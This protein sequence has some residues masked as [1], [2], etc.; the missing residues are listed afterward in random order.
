MLTVITA[1]RWN[2]LPDVSSRPSFLEREIKNKNL[3]KLLPFLLLI[4]EVAR[5]CFGICYTLDTCCSAN[6]TAFHATIALAPIFCHLI[7]GGR[8]AVFILYPIGELTVNGVH[9]AMYTAYCSFVVGSYPSC[10]TL[11]HSASKIH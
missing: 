7:G 5:I 6:A 11:V 1:S 3:R 10:A 4:F 9:I 2:F 8:L